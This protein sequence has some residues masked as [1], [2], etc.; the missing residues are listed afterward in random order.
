M[1]MKHI[2][3]EDFHQVVIEKGTANVNVI[4]VRTPEKFQDA[5]IEGALSIPLSQLEDSLDKLD[6]EKHYYVICQAERFSRQGTQILMDN[7]FDGT[8]V[9]SGMNDYPGETV[10]GA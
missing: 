6:K 5:H 1:E 9:T 2:S 4:D 8:N 7:G 10:S 3:V